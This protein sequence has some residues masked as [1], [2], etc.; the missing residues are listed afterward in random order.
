MTVVSNASPLCYLVLIGHAELLPKLYK[1]I[2]TTRTVITELCHPD[3]P[4]AVR[5]WARSPPV[6]LHLDADPSEPDETLTRLHA[7]ER[8]AIWLAESLKADVVLLDE[9][10]ARSAA[11]RRGLRVSGLLA[12]VRDGGAAGLLDVA[13]AIDR[14]RQTNFRVTPALLR[15][16]L[17]DTHES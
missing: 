13:S 1:N 10:A 12:V 8:S 6:W 5:S 17:P 16:I 3:A 11:L 9:A 14:L 7:G 4:E 2:H 15:S